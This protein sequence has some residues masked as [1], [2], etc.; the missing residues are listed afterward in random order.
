ML[1][2]QLLRE[3]I[4]WPVLMEYCGLAD[5][6]QRLFICW[7]C[8]LRSIGYNPYT[9]VLLASNWRTSKQ[10]GRWPIPFSISLPQTPK[11]NR[12]WR[13]T[14]VISAEVKTSMSQIIRKR[15]ST[16]LNAR[17]IPGLGLIPIHLPMS[18]KECLEETEEM[19]A[20]LS[21]FSYRALP[22]MQQHLW[23]LW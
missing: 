2:W 18:W 11:C 1:K 17:Q 10:R 20:S 14:C 16:D 15:K 9:D 7:W 4:L 22:R 6:N 12:F 5:I 13:Y 19:K 21:I 23:D 3:R 8:S